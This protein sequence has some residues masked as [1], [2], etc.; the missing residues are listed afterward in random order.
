[1]TH[2]EEVPL[3]PVIFT[4]TQALTLRTLTVKAN[5]LYQLGLYNLLLKVSY[6][7]YPEVHGL[8]EFAVEVLNPCKI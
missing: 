3:N 5:D 7:N 6:A 2:G 8:I 4:E 1:M